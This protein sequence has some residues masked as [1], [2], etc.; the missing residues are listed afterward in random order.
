M[1]AG[2][3]LPDEPLHIATMAAALRAQVR[4]F[5]IDEAEITTL[6]RDAH[7]VDRHIRAA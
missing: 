2:V 7:D 5:Q 3:P 1:L 4:Q 6:S